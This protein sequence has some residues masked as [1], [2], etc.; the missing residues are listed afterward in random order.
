MEFGVFLRVH[1]FRRRPPRRK[2]HPNSVV[3]LFH[4][5]ECS[6]YREF[7]NDENGR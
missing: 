3:T 4:V 6:A 1:L 5:I 2:E 7:R